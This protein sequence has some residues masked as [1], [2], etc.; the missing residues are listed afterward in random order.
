VSVCCFIYFTITSVI[1]MH[2][3][4]CCVFAMLGLIFGMIVVGKH[5]V[6]AI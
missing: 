4:L 2:E 5:V 6:A 1:F 3:R